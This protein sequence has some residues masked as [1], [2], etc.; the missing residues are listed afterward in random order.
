MTEIQRSMIADSNKDS[1]HFQS[2]IDHTTRMINLVKIY[3]H[4]V[5]LFELC[6]VKVTKG[7]F[8]L[9]WFIRIIP[10]NISN[11]LTHIEAL[12]VFFGLKGMIPINSF[13]LLDDDVVCK[14]LRLIEVNKSEYQ[15][16][17]VIAGLDQIL[18]LLRELNFA[19]SHN[20]KIDAFEKAI[21]KRFS[22]STFQRIVS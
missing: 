13:F 9:G 6:R 7:K 14:S 2:R 8:E 1:F 22:N 11:P 16:E 5:H 12:T 19:Y 10:A 15:K 4:T 21:K 17:L 18:P 20:I 3:S